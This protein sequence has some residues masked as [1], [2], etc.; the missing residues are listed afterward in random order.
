M[1]APEADVY[2]QNTLVGHIARTEMGTSF[3]YTPE[4]LHTEGAPVAT[5]LP[6]RE[7]PYK[8]PAGALAPY[9]TGLLP[10]GRRL[11]V[12]KNSLKAS[13]DDELTLLLAVGKDTVGDVRV[14]PHGQS[15]PVVTATI[16]EIPDLKKFHEV[17]FSD[18]LS[19]A[20]FVDQASL[21]G[22]QE[23]VSGKMLTVPLRNANEFY[24]LKLN[25][26]EYPLVVENESF[27][28][29]QF[30]RLNART[31]V[32]KTHLVHDAYGEPGL[33]VK[34]FDRGISST[35]EIERFAVEDTCQLLNRYP[36]DKY[37]LS[38]EAIGMAASSICTNPTLAKQE[39][40]RQFVYA[41]LTGNGDLH[42]KNLSVFSQDSH[43]WELSPAYDIPSTAP[44]GDQSMALELAGKTR[45]LS[46]KTFLQ[47]ASVLGLREAAARR[48]ISKMLSDTEELLEESTFIGF[49]SHRQ[50]Q[51]TKTLRNRRL[52]LSAEL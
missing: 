2:K 25:S 39:V 52:S 14:I 45:G 3:Y 49:D 38:A 33:L 9:F 26:P 22:V 11:T 17:R 41:W 12:L 29:E 20:G 16:S 48:L 27:F 36:A 44:Y 5:T 18:L 8:Y 37:N 50:K 1:N 34:R 51:L 31:G 19:E 46:F 10:E 4:Y 13:R 47:F 23:K 6:L 30:R 21:P 28:I 43:H 32:V 35:G 15:L 24:L 7:E 42:A 40:L